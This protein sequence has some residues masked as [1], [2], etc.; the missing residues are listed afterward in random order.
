M[1]SRLPRWVWSGAWG[2]AV[3]AGMVNVVG[4]LGFKHQAVTHLTGTTT[5]LGA[6]IADLDGDAALHF[7]SIIGSF[8]AGNVISGFLIRDTT[9]QLGR[10]YGVA[11]LLESLLL[12]VAVPFMDRGHEA[13]M[14]CAA[15]AC[16]LQNAMVSTYSG[17][18]VRT[19]HL[20]GM[21]T[22]LGIFLG[23]AL[24]GLPVDLRRL[25]LCFLVI[26]GFLLG[27]ITGAAAFRFLG[28]ATLFIPAALT[29]STALACGL[30]HSRKRHQN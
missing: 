1:I 19:T 3:V 11:L 28:H 2:L 5:G 4:L 29:A 30:Y 8:V 26:S 10:R 9:L 27:G 15:C 17:A 14:Y 20:S 16:G 6:A 7:G 22:D 13:G 21:F 24:R 25:R 18:V 23:H 12:A